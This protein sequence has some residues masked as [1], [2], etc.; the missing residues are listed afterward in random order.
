MS[1]GDISELLDLL[2]PGD[3]LTHCFSGA[4]N[5]I[6]QDGKLVPAAQAA[7][8]R[9]VL[10]DIGHGGGSFDYT[11]AEPAIEQGLIPD[12]ISS[13]IHVFSA[14]SP[15]RPFLPWVMSKFLN[16]G[17][18]LEDVL[19]R[20]TAAPAA[21]IDRVAKLGTLEIGAPADV[22]VMELVEGPVTFEDTMRN[23]REGDRYLRPVHTIAGG[24][25]YG[26]PYNAP[27][28]RT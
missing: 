5:N 6:V 12:L 22:A 13:D 28:S 18:S 10:F 9:G 11:V 1:P 23:T 20:A 21:M 19:L 25:P 16:L 24:V 7:Q 26:R 8:E 2:R 3:I 15:G 27:F 4:G 14:N 17:M